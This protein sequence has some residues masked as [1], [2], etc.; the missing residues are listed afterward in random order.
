MHWA[1]NIPRICAG[2]CNRCIVEVG[3]KAEQ[4]ECDGLCDQKRHRGRHFHHL[5]FE[6][7]HTVQHRQQYVFHQD[8]SNVLREFAQDHK[9]TIEGVVDDMWAKSSRCVA[10]LESIYRRLCLGVGYGLSLWTLNQRQPS[11]L[12][13]PGRCRKN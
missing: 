1:R 8:T 7:H 6:L 3:E 12:A 2:A 4:K 11:I 13:K 10:L 9:I 5:A